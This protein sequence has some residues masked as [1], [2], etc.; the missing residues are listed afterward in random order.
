[1]P[2]NDQTPLSPLTTVAAGAIQV[3]ELFMSYVNAGFTR[4]EALQLI[5][6][7]MTSGMNNMNGGNAT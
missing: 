4:N 6:L 2:E 3:H 5:M 7:V 1:M